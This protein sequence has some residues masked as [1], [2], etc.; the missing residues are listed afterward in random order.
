MTF[1]VLQLYT[2]LLWAVCSAFV[3]IKMRNQAKYL[4]TADVEVVCTPAG[5]PTQRFHLLDN[6]DS[7]RH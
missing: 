1:I 2:L 3:Q 7:P 4:H 5:R 6:V